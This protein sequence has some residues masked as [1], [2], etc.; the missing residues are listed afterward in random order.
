MGQPFVRQG[1]SLSCD[2]DWHRC[3]Y[4]HEGDADS[5]GVI[6]R[7]YLLILLGSK[8]P[9]F[10]FSRLS[11]ADPVLGVEMASIKALIST[12]IVLPKLSSRSEAIGRNWSCYITKR[13]WVHHFLQ[14][15][16]QQISVN[17]ACSSFKYGK[18]G[19]SRNGN[20]EA[21][22]FRAVLPT[23][24]LSESI[25]SIRRKGR[26]STGL[27]LPLAA[28]EEPFVFQIFSGPTLARTVVFSSKPMSSY[29]LGQSKRSLSR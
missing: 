21:E 4:G 1:H 22:L 10:S 8:V 2:D 12:G 19:F 20:L 3:Y 18:D 15:P 6:P 29:P 26:W 5:I 24:S 28:V 17:E 27:R 11:G 9:Q 14:P 23:D 25:S 7:S 16:V 13:F